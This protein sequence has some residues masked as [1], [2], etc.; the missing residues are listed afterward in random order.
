MCLILS[1]GALNEALDL[2]ARPNRGGWR[3]FA[4]F[5]PGLS[6]TRS[7]NALPHRHGLL[8]HKGVPL[9]SLNMASSVAVAGLPG[10][11]WPECGSPFARDL[12]QRGFRRHKEKRPKRDAGALQGHRA[13]TAFGA[14]GLATV[15]PQPEMSK[16]HRFGHGP[17]LSEVHVQTLMSETKG[18]PISAIGHSPR[19]SGSSC[20]RV[21]KNTV[22]K[23]FRLR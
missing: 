14:E 9:A 19:Q 16:G 1:T 23:S 20:A 15:S 10:G 13:A 17:C 2:P 5:W 18:G 12:K 21:R 8:P 11:L 7:G 22:A 3:E 4:I 6:S